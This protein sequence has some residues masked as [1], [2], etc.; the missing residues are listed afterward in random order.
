M[1]IL[2]D[3]LDEKAW[4]TIR[5]SVNGDGG[6]VAETQVPEREAFTPIDGARLARRSTLVDAEGNVIQTWN[7]EK[8]EDAA[9][10]DAVQ[11]AIDELRQT[12]PRA[13]VIAEPETT[14]SHLLTGYPVGDHH[15][16]MLAWKHEVGASY[17]LEIG[18]NLLANATDYLVAK[19]PPSEH[20]VI[21]LLGDFVHY[22][23]MIPQT[24]QNRNPLDADGRASKMVR[25]AMRTVRRLIEA[26]AVKHL[27]VHVIIEFGNHDPYSM[28]WLMEGIRCLYE[29]NP[30][31]EIDCSPSAF[32]YHRFGKN[33]IATHHGDRVKPAALPEIMAEDRAADWGETTHRTWWTGHVHNDAVKEYRGCTVETFGIL[34]PGDA[35]SHSMGYR[36]RR[37][38][39]SIVFHAEHGEVDRHTFNPFMLEA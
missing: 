9:R 10:W 16:G 29:D 37:S 34:A 7:I 13:P 39:K 38:M 30:R 17:D 22:D 26:V 27:K 2:S 14:M 21:A 31:I 23:S 8:P 35:W 33:L 32:H 24:P 19:A 6:I 3:A 11:E 1:S 15:M 18:E 12:L 20:A 4:H 5:R 28:L 25:A 36:A